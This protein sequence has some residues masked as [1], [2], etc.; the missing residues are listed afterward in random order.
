MA[1]ASD[2]GNKDGRFTFNEIHQYLLQAVYPSSFSKSD[3]Q[4]LRKRAKFFSVNGAD[5]YYTGRGENI[6]ETTFCNCKYVTS[7]GFSFLAYKA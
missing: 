2:D 4:A 5:L 1:T 6:T 7:H 3:K